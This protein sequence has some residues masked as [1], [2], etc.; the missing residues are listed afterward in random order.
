MPGVAYGLGLDLGLTRDLTGLILS[1]VNDN[2]HVVVDIARS[3][4]GTR[5][6]PVDLLDVEATV[7]DL[8]R[9]FHA[10]VHLDGWNGALLAQRLQR[11]GVTS[12]RTHTM[13]SSR[14]DAYATL[15]KTLFT[16]RQV[17][18]PRDAELLEQLENL[19]GEELRR[20]DQV[21]FTAVG[22]A[23]DDLPCA[24]CLSC[25]GHIAWRATQGKV[26]M[27]ETRIGRVEL[28]K[29]ARVAPRITSG[30]GRCRV[31]LPTAAPRSCR[32][33]CGVR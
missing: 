7:L 14:L 5:Q 11:Q 16:N 18:I 21:R 2:G 3:W 20:R 27:R 15:L 8:A 22:E 26:V 6:H 17:Q 1:H 19:Q 28:P 13:E 4:R 31:R 10:A 29:S 23:H 30:N 24:L 33:V 25:E 9:R 12:V 32:V